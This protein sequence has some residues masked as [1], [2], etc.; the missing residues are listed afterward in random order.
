[1]AELGLQYAKYNT[2]DETTGKYSA[3]ASGQ[4]APKSIG[5]L[6]DSSFEKTNDTAELYADDGLAEYYYG[7][8]E[9]TLNATFANVTD[10]TVAELFGHTEASGE[11]TE[12]GDDIAPAVGYGQVVT[13]MVN[14]EMKYKAELLVKVVFNSIATSHQTKGK[15]VTF[16]TTA[17]T[18]KVMKLAESMNGF[19]ADTYRKFE[20]FDT[21]AAA[22]AQIDEWLTPSAS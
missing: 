7:F 8:V 19:P 14:G 22:K 1:M 3:F 15:N 12:K 6:V 21:L 10:E 17:L 2:I 4:T 16:Q 5:K 11:V 18:G 13:K 9:G 20:T